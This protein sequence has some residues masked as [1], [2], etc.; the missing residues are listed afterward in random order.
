MDNRKVLFVF[1]AI[2]LLPAFSIQELEFNNI[3]SPDE[4]GPYH[5]GHYKISY[6]IPNYGR[7]W[8]TIRYPALRDGWFAPKDTSGAP[9][10]GI[11]VANGWSG[12]EW[13]IKWIPRHLASYGFVTISFTPPNKRS[14]ITTQWAHGFHGGIEELKSWNNIWFSPIYDILDVETFGGIGLSMGGGG[15]IEAT[16]AN[17]SEI[18]AAVALA[19]ATHREAIIAAEKIDVPIQIQVGD[20]DGMVPPSHV[21]PYYTDYISDDITKEYLAINGGN[22]IGFLDDFFARFAERIG[23]DSPRDIEFE[24][25]RRISRK[26]FTAWFQYHLKDLSEYYTFIFGEE[27]QKDLDTGILSELIYNIL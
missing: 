24:E 22:H 15:C 23:L 20:K 7:Y 4:P 21:L 3:L 13:N 5:I 9:Y 18:D 12:S 11:V 27:A 19:P 10:P 1:A 26:Y 6:N 14:G 8:A 16:G 17:D 2:I 25:Q